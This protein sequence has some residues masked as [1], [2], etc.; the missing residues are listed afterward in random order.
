MNRIG[1][2]DDGL[3]LLAKNGK[4]TPVFEVGIHLHTRSI[5]PRKVVLQIDLLARAIQDAD[6]YFLDSV[7]VRTPNIRNHELVTTHF[8][9]NK[10]NVFLERAVFIELPL[11]HDPVLGAEVRELDSSTLLLTDVRC[12]TSGKKQ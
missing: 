7:N 3:C 9:A 11:D 1:R 10:R 4:A 12:G 8:I 5:H 6:L 2:T